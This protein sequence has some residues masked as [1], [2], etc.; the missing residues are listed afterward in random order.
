MVNKAFI[1]FIALSVLGPP[2]MAKTRAPG[3]S[4]VPVRPLNY[5]YGLM[6][7]YLSY[8]VKI[9]AKELEE[10][11]I[12]LFAGKYSFNEKD[13]I[14]KNK[15]L[16]EVSA[17]LQK[18]LQGMKGSTHE[19]RVFLRAELG[20]YDNAEEG[21]N[22]DIVNAYSC[23]DLTPLEKSLNS[24]GEEAGARS[25]VERGLLFGKVSRIKIF[26]LN[27]AD[28]KF[29]KYPA[30]KKAAL[31]KSRTGEGG[32]VNRE[33]YTVIDIEIL[34]PDKYRKAYDSIEKNVYVPG[35]ENNYFMLARI[36]SIEAYGDL[37][38]KDKLGDLGPHTRVVKTE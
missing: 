38:L 5:Y 29:I 20:E 33:I 32:A 1:V 31:L 19:Y 14:K 12:V 6:E 16:Q 22:C 10:T 23:I 34:P 26:F 3:P 8:C 7:Y 36:K 24:P 37:D 17:K 4:A 21:F 9:G 30:E 15:G 27:S 28:Y 25:L 11:D 18:M 2:A 35:M 13:E